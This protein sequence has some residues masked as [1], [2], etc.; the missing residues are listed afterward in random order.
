MCK[1]SLGELFI[2]YCSS[3]L[4]IPKSKNLDEHYTN[5]VNILFDIYLS[6]SKRKCDEM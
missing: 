5:P 4:S 2:Q 3:I 1:F 6:S